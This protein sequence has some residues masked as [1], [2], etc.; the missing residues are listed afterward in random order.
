[1][2]KTTIK[3]IIV[4]LV[5]FLSTTLKINAQS[6][7][8][9]HLSVANGL[10]QSDINT[11]YQSPNGYMWFGTHDGLNKYDGYNFTHYRPNTKIGNTI[12]SNLIVDVTGD[13]NNNLWIGTTGGGISFF[14]NKTEKFLNYTHKKKSESS[15]GSNYVRDLLLDT[16]NRLW[17]ST[18]KGLDVTDIPKTNDS[19]VFQHIT[20]PKYFER[21]EVMYESKSGVLYFG[22]IGRV[23]RLEEI[24]K[25]FHF[26]DLSHEIGRS[27]GLIKSITED[28]SGRIIVAT[29]KGL[30][31]QDKETKKLVQFSDKASYEVVLDHKNNLWV[32]NEN[33]GGLSFYRNKPKDKLPVF[34]KTFK[35]SPINNKS[36]SKDIITSLYKDFSGI[37]WIGTNGGGV[38]TLDPFRKPFNHTKKKDNYRSISHNKIRAIYEDVHQNLWIGTEGG[39]LNYRIKSTEERKFPP[40]VQINNSAK[41]PFALTTLTKNNKKLLLIGSGDKP[42]FSYIDITNPTAKKLQKVVNIPEVKSSVFTL[43]ID[44][45]NQIWLG[46]YSKGVYVL[47]YKKD[48]FIVKKHFTNTGKKGQVPSNIIRNIY[49]DSH[50][51]MWFATGDGLSKMPYGEFDKE[52][53]QFIS[54]HHDVT[55]DKSISYN[56]ILSIYESEKGDLWFGTLGGGLNKLLSKPHEKKARFKVYNTT[57]GLPNDAVK[58]ILEDDKGNLWLS[59]NMGLTKFDPETEKFKNYNIYDGLQSNEFQELACFK[60]KNGRVLFGGINGFNEFSP[61]KIKDN[62]YA[63]ITVIT[64]LFLFNNELKI[65]EKV[66]GDIPLKQSIND[67]SELVF[68]YHQ[69]SISLEFSGIQYSSPQKNKYAYKLDGFEDKWNY[70][71]SYKRFAT[72]TNLSPGTYTFKVKSSNGDSVWNHTPKKIKITITPP[73]WKTIWAYLLYAFLV[74][75]FLIGLWKF[76]LFKS[77]KKHELELQELEKK[78]QAELQYLK[79]EFFTNISHEFRTPLTL[80]KGPIEYLL[81]KGEGLSKDVLKNQYKLMGKN[82]DYLLRLVTQLLDFQKMDKGQMDLVLY[83]KNISEFI[84]EVAEPF[85][86]ISEKKKIKY[87]V[88]AEQEVIESYFNPDALEKIMNNLLSNAFKF[89]PDNGVI[90]VYVYVKKTYH[91]DR[92][93]KKAVFDRVVIEVKDSGSGISEAKKEHI[94]NRFYSNSAKELANP[95]GTGIGLSYTKSLIDVHQGSIAVIDNELGGTTFAVNLPLEKQAYVNKP[96]IILGKDT[97]ELNLTTAY[98]SSTHQTSLKDEKD[99]LEVIK[100]RPE[101]PIVLIVDDHEDIRF[102]IKQLLQ[103]KYNVLEA[104]NG[105]EGLKIAKEKIPNI[106]ISDYVMPIMDGVN[107]CMQCKEHSETSHIPF[108]LLTAK[109]SDENKVS[110]LESGADDYITKPFNL[111][112]LQL[113]I[114]NIIAKRDKLR[115]QFNQEIILKPKEVT[116]TSSDEIFLEK[117][118]AIVEKNMMNTEFSVEMLVQEMKISRSNLYLKLKEITGLS[119]S[120]FIRSIRLKRAV[121]LLETSDMSVKEIMYMTGFNSPSYFAKCFKKQFKMTPSEYVNQ[122]SNQ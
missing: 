39:G 43:H 108:L 56:Y 48:K 60:R 52:T 41:K 8:F 68:K 29:S 36:L 58:G 118:M 25:Q 81:S 47:V 45:L 23:F 46:T 49:Q 119:S 54:Y 96:N 11:I 4:L 35:N 73:F 77:G 71:D 33:E 55:D 19:L 121:Q 38:N 91:S 12:N 44:H 50:K 74:I 90:D 9:K 120:E 99:D 32:A 65:G 80:I 94:F 95:T 78:K 67:T 116:V 85:Q 61:D 26:K 72:Y 79:M 83:S 3:K 18:S 59:S 93:T 101:L 28:A 1:M 14:D 110:G 51:N 42:A 53:P 112:L 10:S 100:E 16:K 105:E 69:N 15:I 37:L 106:I 13:A 30:Y 87:T 117:A 98:V 84:R 6:V 17:V 7:S 92:L 82:T 102:L 64:K 113:K 22:M 21:V 109:T 88:R 122:N 76:T 2:L 111:E 75:A 86:F 24:N 66:E 27:K 63:P 5:L 107:F 40:F 115:K 57:N 97:D 114:K 20:L 31:I 104:E 34:W 103:E 89:C 70:T 62:T